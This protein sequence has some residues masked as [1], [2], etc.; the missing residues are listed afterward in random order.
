MSNLPWKMTVRGGESLF[1]VTH[2]WEV[3]RFFVDLAVG[4]SVVGVHVWLILATFRFNARRDEVVQE[5]TK[6][7]N[8]L[9]EGKISEEKIPCEARYV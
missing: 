5:M 7:M 4:L 6:W 3:V 9:S 1:P 8:G 2:P